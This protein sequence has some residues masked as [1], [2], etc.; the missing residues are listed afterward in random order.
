MKQE[1][2]LIIGGVACGPKAASR[3]K[4]I[5]PSAQVTIIEKGEILS[6]AGCGMPYYISGDIK[7]YRV[8][9]STPMGVVRDTHYY[10]NVKDVTVLNK[11][12]VEKIDRNNKT[13]RA[14]TIETGESA[15]IPY[16]RLVLAVGGQPH[17]PAFPGTDLKGVYNLSTVDDARRIKE[18][19]KLQG[20]SAVIIGGGLIGIEV[21]EAFVKQGMS[22]T[23]I[24]KLEHLLPRF[25]DPEMAVHLHRELARNNVTVMTDTIVTSINGDDQG[26]VISVSTEKGGVAADLVLIAIGIKPNIRLAQEAGLAIGDTGAIKVNE[27]LQTSDQDIYAGGDCVENINIITGKPVHAPLG[28]TSNKHGRVIADNIC[29][30]PTRFPGVMATAICR[31]FDLNIARTGLSEIQARMEGYDCI[32]L[33]N[34][35]FDMSHF[36]PGASQI[37]MKL[38]VDR[39]TRKVIGGQVVGPGEAAKRIDILSTAM[40]FGATVEDIAHL[41][42]AYAPPFSPAMDSVIVSANI[43]RNKIDGIV[44]SIAPIEMQAKITQGHDFIILDVRTPQEFASYRIAD[45]RVMCIPLGKLRSRIDALPRDKEII[46]L[47]RI[48]LRGYEAAIILQEHGFSD[49]KFL[50]GGVDAW[51]FELIGTPGKPV[52]DE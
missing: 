13:V 12:I 6:Y 45:G 11:T 44:K 33:I 29:G 21:T 47:C 8:F 41:D 49:V 4:R 20:K 39:R 18:N 9:M 50:D 10:K 31:I 23:V 34:P 27:Y 26:R 22:V 15:E 14:L 16:D 32:T 17:K 52:F 7:D 43:A 36:F 24:E 38:V 3:I 2:I 30:I 51:P 28:S 37:I 40:S 42:L 48:S 19:E 35:S 46:T 5:N 25:I 1:K